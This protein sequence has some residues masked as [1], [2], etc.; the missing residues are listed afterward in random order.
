MAGLR[1]VVTASRARSVGDNGAGRGSD[2]AACDS[3]AYGSTGQ[4]SNHGTGTTSDQCA[5]HHA[6][7]SRGLTSGQRQGHHGHHK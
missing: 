4:T 1:A 3:T 7:L 6:I 2:Q 5:A